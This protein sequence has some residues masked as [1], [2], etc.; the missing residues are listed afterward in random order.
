[1]KKEFHNDKKV[2]SSQGYNKYKCICAKNR[3]SK[4]CVAKQC[5][6]MKGEIGSSSIIFKILIT[7]SQTLTKLLDN[8]NQ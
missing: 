8:K 5:D 1:M 4:L 3:P 7:V 2:N 6:R